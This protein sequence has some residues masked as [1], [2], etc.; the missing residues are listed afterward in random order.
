MGNRM[1]ILQETARLLTY[2][3]RVDGDEVS[4]DLVVDLRDPPDWFVQPTGTWFEH[5]DLT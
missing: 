1:V 3:H 4:L 5:L 2:F